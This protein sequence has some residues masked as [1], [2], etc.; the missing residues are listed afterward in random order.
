MDDEQRPWWTRPPEPGSDPQSESEPESEAA[1]PPPSAAAPPADRTVVTFVP[2][3]YTRPE[4]EP[5]LPPPRPPKPIVRRV[6]VTPP[7][8]PPPPP[9][10]V[11]TVGQD[12]RDARTENLPPV[13]DSIFATFGSP[14]SGNR[15]ASQPIPGRAGRAGR[16]GRQQATGPDPAA[17]SLD[18]PHRVAGLLPHVTLPEPRVLMLGVA[19]ALVTVLI[20]VVVLLNGSKTADDKAKIPTAAPTA[21]AGA[22]AIA[23]KVPDG[24]KQVSSVDAAAQLLKVDQGPGGSIVEAWGWSD[25]NGR[26]LVVTSIASAGGDKRTLRVVHIA[27]LDGKPR[28]LRV[29]KDPRLPADCEG[30]GTAGFTPKALIVRDLDGDNLAEVISGW[31]SRCGGKEAR[32]QI[33]L[34][35]ITDGKKYILRGQGVL[36]TVGT[37]TPS[38]GA[39]RW[40]DNYLKVLAAQ[41]R[42]LYG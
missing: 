20:V 22:E 29:M 30:S 18:G 6:A 3:N 33:R 24:L 16:A 7:P 10:L 26:N 27:G 4:T 8:P 21:T 17:E 39:A 41:Y 2:P 35:L 42:K 38:P 9:P 37:F 11:R 36:G 23:G 5:E 19:A 34:A 32:S 13:A 1:L 15:R 12:P 28:T 40:P 31:T 25:K 14:Q